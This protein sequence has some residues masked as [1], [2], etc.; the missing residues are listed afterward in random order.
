V[1]L[2]DEIVTTLPDGVFLEEIKQSG[3]VVEFQGQAQSNA[4][5]SSF[6]RNIDDSAWLEKPKLDLI[7][8]KESTDTG[9]SSFKLSV[10]QVSQ[11]TGQGK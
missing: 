8:T 7:E 5:V 6:M 10:R 4:R 1:H 2:F 3:P 9:L 11:N